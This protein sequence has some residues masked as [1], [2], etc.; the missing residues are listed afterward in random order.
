LLISIWIDCY[1]SNPTVQVDIRLSNDVRYYVYVLRFLLN[2]GDMLAVKGGDGIVGAIGPI[3]RGRSRNQGKAP[4]FDSSTTSTS[5][6]I[7][8]RNCSCR[9]RSYATR[10]RAR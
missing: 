9:G 1:L 8:I 10:S 2:H 3:M 6:A 5:W 4:R 7:G